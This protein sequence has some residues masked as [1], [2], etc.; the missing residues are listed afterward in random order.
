M[1]KETKQILELLGEYLK[2]N[3]DIRFCQ[4]LHA[5]N[6][7]ETKNI[8]SGHNGED[9]EECI[10]DNYYNTDEKVLERIKQSNSI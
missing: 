3:P 7:N 2:K 9:V 4:A 1:K 6:I 10:K 8:Y 5:L